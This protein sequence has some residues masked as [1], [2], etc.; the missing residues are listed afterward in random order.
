MMRMNRATLSR[1]LRINKE[2]YLVWEFLQSALPL[3]CRCLLYGRAAL[4][5]PKSGT[6]LAVVRE[7]AD[8]LRVPPQQLETAL[9][10]PKMQQYL[11]F[12]FRKRDVD[13][14]PQ[15]GRTWIYGLASEQE[16]KWCREMY[17]TVE[18]SAIER[19]EDP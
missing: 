17:D 5:V 8:A 11:K 7:T 14:L 15:M 1:R 4:V 13:L 2:P 19:K 16:K 18:G 12:F 3:D 9:Q 10:S 6:I